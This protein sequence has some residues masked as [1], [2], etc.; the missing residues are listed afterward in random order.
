MNSAL[1]APHHCRIDLEDLAV[2]ERVVDSSPDPAT[3]QDSRSR[4]T[5]EMV[6]HRLLRS[7]DLDSKGLHAHLLSTIESIKQSNPHRLTEKGK[8][9]SDETS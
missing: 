2:N 9:I 8:P 1:Q 3:R 6:R 7:P 4:Q 5:H